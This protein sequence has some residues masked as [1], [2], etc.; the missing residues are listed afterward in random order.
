M[1]NKALHFYINSSKFV[2]CENCLLRTHSLM[3]KSF[4]FTWISIIFNEI[5]VA[6]FDLNSQM[7]F[8]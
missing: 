2:R 3:Q 6:D 1:I 7:R 4:S 5:L 8:D